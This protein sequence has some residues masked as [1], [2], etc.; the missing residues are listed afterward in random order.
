VYDEDKM[1]SDCIDRVEKSKS[2]AYYYLN[3]KEAQKKELKAM[4][5]A[6]CA[7]VKNEI[8]P[9]DEAA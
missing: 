6:F 3:E 4:L 8:Q 5:K 2:F 7:K 9:I 1:I